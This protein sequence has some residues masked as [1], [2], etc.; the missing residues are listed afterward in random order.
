VLSCAVVL[1]SVFVGVCAMVVH[2]AFTSRRCGPSTPNLVAL[3]LKHTHTF[4]PLT[5]LQP[6]Q[7]SKTTKILLSAQPAARARSVTPYPAQ[8]TQHSSTEL[9]PHVMTSC[10]CERVRTSESCQATI[11][12]RRVCFMCD[13]APKETWATPVNTPPRPSIALDMATPQSNAGRRHTADVQD[14]E[15]KWIRVSMSQCLSQ[16]SLC[17]AGPCSSSSRTVIE[18]D[19]NATPHCRSAWHPRVLHVEQ[20]WAG[21]SANA[22]C[23]CCL[24]VG[25]RGGFAPS[26]LCASILQLF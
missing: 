11:T 6:A 15:S 13:H 2:T 9:R 1:L 23:C 21:G 4:G 20:V 8:Q 18:V 12:P 25:C 3:A 16:S 14:A 10:T 17:D 19:A 22:F 5:R 26:L 7:L 24:L